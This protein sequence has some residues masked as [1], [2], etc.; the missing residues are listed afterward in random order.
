MCK[1]TLREI[2]VLCVFL[3][4]P[5]M[6]GQT[7]PGRYALILEDV[8][9]S[10]RFASKESRRLAEATTY[11]QQIEKRQSAVRTQLADR[12]IQ[13]TGSVDTVLNAIFLL[14]P[15]E[16]I[17]ELSS[18]PGVKGI[19]P[20]KRYHMSLNRATQVLNA[21]AAWNALGGLQAAGQ[22]IKI[23]VLDSGIDQTHPAFQDSSLAMPG[24]YPICNGSDC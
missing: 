12:R 8:P 23:G 15:P 2:L 17:A 24:G 14:A 4:V 13:V 19:V 11:Q 1:L 18:L 6:S 5:A 16:R 7:A 10:E 9:L 22:G 21:P 20:M 3:V